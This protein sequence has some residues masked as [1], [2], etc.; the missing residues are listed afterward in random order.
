MQLHREG[1]IAI[2]EPWKG[3]FLQL[4]TRLSAEV[5]HLQFAC[6]GHDGG[7]TL[8]AVAGQIG[9]ITTLRFRQL[10]TSSVQAL[11]YSSMIMPEHCLLTAGGGH[12]GTQHAGRHDAAGRAKHLSGLLAAENPK[13]AF[14]AIHDLQVVDMTAGNTLG[15]MAGRI[16][17][18]TFLG[19]GQL[20]A[21]A[22]ITALLQGGHPVESVA[23]GVCCLELICKRSLH[24]GESCRQ[25]RWR[26]GRGA[27]RMWRCVVSRHAGGQTRLVWGNGT[28][29]TW[30]DR[31]PVCMATTTTA[32][33][34]PL[35][36]RQ[37]AVVHLRWAHQTSG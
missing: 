31:R 26:C 28:G 29:I 18:T 8:V 14:V 6:G 25:R 7:N 35:S 3:R 24:M 20:E 5:F 27:P 1:A 33:M 17:H 36:L 22:R 15:E 10:I 9:L 37:A 34:P 13:Y 11:S 16:G 4:A 23:A 12:D 21:G 30:H 2:R 32:A 19:Y